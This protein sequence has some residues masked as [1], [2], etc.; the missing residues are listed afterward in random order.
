[1]GKVLISP[2]LMTDIADAVRNKI[3]RT[4]KL[5]ATQMAET[6]LNLSDGLSLDVL[7][8]GYSSAKTYSVGD[9]VTYQDAFYVCAA[10]ISEPESFDLS[11]WRKTTVAEQ[12]SPI[13]KADVA[14]DKYY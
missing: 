5:T 14:D 4:D 2:S 8:P 1:M 9:L 3:G 6:I 7:A 13:L 12:L 11:H 10:T